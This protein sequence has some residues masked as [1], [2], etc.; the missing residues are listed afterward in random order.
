MANTPAGKLVWGD[1][2]LEL[3]LEHM[4]ERWT[5][6]LTGETFSTQALGETH[7]LTLARLFGTFPYALLRAHRT[8]ADHSEAS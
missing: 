2:W 4:H 8:G 3:P 5:N 1:T 7:G 6:T